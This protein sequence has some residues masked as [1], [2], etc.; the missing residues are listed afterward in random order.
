L[1]AVASVMPLLHALWVTPPLWWAL[2]AVTGF[3][4]AGAYLI[5][6][7][8]LNERATNETRG[9]IF[10]VYTALNFGVITLGQMLMLLAD[11]AAFPL[12]S[13]VSVLLS[14]AAV[15]VALTRATAPA[16]LQTVRLRPMRLIRA[17]PVGVAACATVGLANGAFWSLGPS[18][19]LA[20]GLDV[21]HVAL[22]MSVTVIGGAL[23]QWPFGRMSDR[24]DR[25]RVMVLVS[26]ASA[27]SG[28]ALFIAARHWSE[29]L[30]PA[31]FLFGAFAF[32]LYGLGVA[33]VNDH[34]DDAA[35]VETASG[36]LLVQGIMSVIGPLLASGF[37]GAIGTGGL[38]LF[39]A[40]VHV[41]MAAYAV[42]RMRVREAP[43]EALKA[44]FTPVTENMPP[45]ATLDP[46]APDEP[47]PA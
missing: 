42:W 21:A 14:L 29:A 47:L 9:T 32:P 13:L 20:A 3:C 41:A 6:E 40:L 2:R 35:F 22:F 10:S 1:L 24:M 18:F 15:P 36:L 33:H 34:I 26:I 37:S 45:P 19:A 38:F 46:R 25:R 39:T 11:P 28:V 7:S 44:P 4:L 8:W 12:F 43:P 16:P 27:V 31:A 5:I 17:S 30:L 23:S